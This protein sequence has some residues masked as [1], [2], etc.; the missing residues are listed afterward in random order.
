MLSFF[1]SYGKFKCNISKAIG[2]RI[3]SFSQEDVNTIIARM[4]EIIDQGSDHIKDLERKIQ[5][6]GKG[7]KLQWT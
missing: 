3:G 4:Q 7:K 6:Q 5:T 1:Q 2:Q